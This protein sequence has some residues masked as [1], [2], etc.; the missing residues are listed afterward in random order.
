MNTVSSECAPSPVDRPMPPP[1]EAAPAAASPL[2]VHAT[3]CDLVM[4]GGI[5]SGVVY[6]LAIVE[7]AKAFRLRSIGGT[8]A[9]A[10]AA[11]TAAAAELG[12]QRFA[13]GELAEDPKS[14]E[15]LGRLPEHLCAADGSGKGTRLLAFFKPRRVLRKPFAVFIRTLSARSMAGRVL[16]GLAALTTQ[17]WLH[18]LLG[19][20]LGAAP[21]LFLPSLSSAWLPALWL[22][23]FAT[24]IALTAAVAGM[25]RSLL[26]ALPDNGYGICSGMPDVGEKHPEEA[27]TAWLCDYLDRLAGQRPDAAGVRKPVTFGDLKKHGIDL[28]MITTSLTLGRPY[29][30]PFGD[31][32]EVRETGRFLFSREEFEGL[33]PKHVV[34]WMIDHAIPVRT[35]RFFHDID[36]TG[37]HALP[38]PEDFPVIVAVRMSLSFPVL[39]SGVPLYSVDRQRACA[40]GS[41]PEVCW[42]TDGG[43]GSN[44]PIHFFDAPLPTR[45][46]FG[47]DLGN[48]DEDC[49]DTV[50]ARVVF[51][52]DN[53]DACNSPWWRPGSEKGF[54]AVVGFLLRIV[55]V[56]K[57]WNHET[58]SCLP[59]FR[60][61]IG[62][63]R[64]SKEEGGLNLTMGPEKIRVL[65]GY[66]RAA[67][68][69]FV[70]RFGAPEHWPQDAEPSK[71]GWDNHQHVR[72]RLWL[73][74][75]TEVLQRL[76]ASV[77]KMAGK[78]AAYARFF[79]RGGEDRSYALG[80]LGELPADPET[81]RFG[82]QAGLTKWLLDELGSISLRLQAS[83][84]AD[85]PQ[86][87][88][89]DPRYRA[90]RP[91]PELK[92]RPRV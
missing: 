60:D 53:N 90:P 38:S 15:E 49:P 11:A 47:L 81:G 22:L 91:R 51:P 17:Y 39:L 3:E 29:R 52:R 10:I 73:A 63:I 68:L 67:G 9:G 12:R 31:D 65:T 43:V 74:A 58:L 8:S 19:F 24:L 92:T 21:L 44:F 5:T 76:E 82:S 45:P 27:L 6:P 56:A 77:S 1:V 33:F 16:R 35:R 62:L 13:A 48:A 7:I 69:E 41:A 79:E 23:I 85:R 86:S 25:A 55:D 4:K 72:L 83:V 64:L 87:R 34:E 78:D 20:A 89:F 54:G 46:T 37:Y 59:G 30:L 61:R 28:Q 66:G 71:M 84:D 50:E 18:A 42:F 40:P 75:M 26:K 88:K 2:R 57:D 70:K 80:G 14:F 32:E 36:L